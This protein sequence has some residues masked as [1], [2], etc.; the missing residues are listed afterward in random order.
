MIATSRLPSPA[1]A[2]KAMPSSPH[3]ADGSLGDVA[4]RLAHVRRCGVAPARIRANHRLAGPHSRERGAARRRNAP[5]RRVRRKARRLR[6]TQPRSRHGRL[7]RHLAGPPR[8][9][10]GKG[11]R[12]RR[13]RSIALH[14]SGSGES[15]TDR[16]RVGGR[17]RDALG[18]DLRRRQ[19]VRVRRILPRAPARRPPVAVRADQPVRA[20]GRRH[21]AGL[22][23]DRSRRGSAEGSLVLRGDPASRFRP[24]FA[25]DERDL[26]DLVRKA[27]FFPIHLQLESAIEPPLLRSWD[28]FAGVPANP[29]IPALADALEQVLDSEESARFVAHLRPRVEEG[30]GVSRTCIAF[31]TG[32]KP[33]VARS[34]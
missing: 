32:V 20:N 28:T 3:D 10:Q 19:E 13:A 21:V 34:A 4:F 26:V 11:A 2:R 1:T 27:G 14:A 30:R 33:G 5:R 23:R 17:G 12:A 16:E 9:L 24:R 31:L 8:L 6:R 25:F 22:R 15:R 29:R 7:Q 18:A